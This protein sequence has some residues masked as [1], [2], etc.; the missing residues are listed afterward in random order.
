MA[1]PL[2]EI[3]LTAAVV[4]P[5]EGPPIERGAVRI[6]GDRIV[7][8][9]RADELGGPMDD[10]GDVVLMPG[11]VNAHTHLELT[12]YQGRLSP[13]PF[14]EWVERLIELRRRDDA[15]MTDRAAIVAGARQ[16]LLAGVT[17]VGDVSRTGAN[18]AALRGVP[19][20]RVCFIE[21]ISGARHSPA[22]A[23]QLAE[24][25]R[26]AAAANHPLERIGVS[27]HAPYSVAWND[28]CRAAALA[29]ERGLTIAMHAGETA[30]EIEWLRTGG[31]PL[32][33][34]VR[35][36]GLP[37]ESS[38]IQ[39]GVMQFLQRAGLT[40]LCPL[41]I[42]MNYTH[43]DEISLLAESQCS[44]AYCPR[45]HA[46][47]GHP[48]HRWRAMLSR[49]VNVCVGTDSLASNSTLSVLDEL[50]M[51]HRL[52]PDLPP[53]VLLRMS[54]LD[55]AR[56]LGVADVCGSL[57]AGKQ[58]DL[59]AVS[60]ENGKDWSTGIGLLGPSSLIKAVWV[61]GRSVVRD[62]VYIEPAEADM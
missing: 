12:G 21:L 24:S 28:L 43:D 52:A 41:L 48:P 4:L 54:T 53:A 32:A 11:F 62:G 3:T 51:L 44:V 46:F 38:P 42:H 33:T 22:N 13:A 35:R 56:A 49:G 58:A 16:S 20:R 23:D 36:L 30:E 47:F 8:V 60:C 15:E 37:T 2:D 59:V 27:P 61:A 50:R 31:G 26:A 5:I 18:V 40:R 34:F 14:W 39:S 7:A 17:C 55:A 25:V 29:Q 1:T 9:G 57:R 10:L 19:I 45:A 6:R